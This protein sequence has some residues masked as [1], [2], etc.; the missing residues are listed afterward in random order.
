MSL[1]VVPLERKKHKKHKTFSRKG[2]KKKM[3]AACFNAYE[4]APCHRTAKES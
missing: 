4:G 1:W 2:A 3:I